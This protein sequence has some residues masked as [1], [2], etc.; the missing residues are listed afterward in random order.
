MAERISRDAG[1]GVR[2]NVF[3]KRIGYV[4]GAGTFSFEAPKRG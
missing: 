2:L 1:V 4:F 3:V